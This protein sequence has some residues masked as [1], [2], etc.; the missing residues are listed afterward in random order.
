MQV[1]KRFNSV[2][3]DNQVWRAKC[4]RLRRYCFI[5][6]KL[7]LKEKEGLKEEEEKEATKKSINWKEV[8]KHAVKRDTTTEEENNVGA[9]H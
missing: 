3:N 1:C 7:G 8:F 9:L 6:L 2:A 4:S 5:R